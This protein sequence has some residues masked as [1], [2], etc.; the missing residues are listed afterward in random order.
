M[1]TMT[2]VTIDVDHPTIGAFGVCSKQAGYLEVATVL[3]AF[4]EAGIPSEL[5]PT[6]VG[7]STALK[8][9]MEDACVG[10]KSLRVDST[11]KFSK[12]VYSIVRTNKARLDLEQEDNDGLGVSDAYLSARVEANGVGGLC[13]VI[14][15]DN[16]EQAAYIRNRFDYHREHFKCSEDL[17]I[18]LSQRVFKNPV[19]KA[20]PRPGNAGGFYFVP[21]GEGL[22]LL[23]RIDTC[24]TALSDYNGRTFRNGVKLYM[25]PMLT[26]IGDVLD[27]IVDSVIDDAE[28]TMEDLE[29]SFNPEKPLGQRALASKARQAMELE[30]KLSAF[31][32][33]M[34]T[35]F[36]DIEERVGEL[37]KRIYLAEMAATKE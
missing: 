31:A 18:F 9:A 13:L 5:H 28:R 10:D 17:S 23:K 30:K 3:H 25:V 24:F 15:P 36:T 19:I 1:H 12:V 32:A 14:K 33:S 35:G 8:R 37:K 29:E 2:D 21:R 27:A 4:K 34:S 11:G 22:D 16:H 6:P 20:T 26:S 7:N